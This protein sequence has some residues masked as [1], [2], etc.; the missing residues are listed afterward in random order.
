MEIHSLKFSIADFLEIQ[1]KFATVGKLDSSLS[2]YSVH[3]KRRLHQIYRNAK[4]VVCVSA[5]MWGIWIQSTDS[6]TL[7]RRWDLV[8][9][10]CMRSSWGHHYIWYAEISRCFKPVNLI[11]YWADLT[12]FYLWV[13]YATGCKNTR[14]V[15]SSCSDNEIY[16]VEIPVT[17]P[18]LLFSTPF[19]THAW[20]R[21]NQ[22]LPWCFNI[23]VKLLQGCETF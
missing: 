14:F 7:N 3:T 9:A 19:I 8:L 5:I 2:S 13:N 1:L 15:S 23:F 4:M 20:C 22:N 17:S 6:T 12:W 16:W 10:C 11:S 18:Q 21:A